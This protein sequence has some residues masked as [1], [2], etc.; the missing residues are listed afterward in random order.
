MPDIPF[1]D[2]TMSGAI[3]GAAAFLFKNVL[4]SLGLELKSSEKTLFV[5]I[6]G[7]IM[8]F[9][10]GYYEIAGHTDIVHCVITGLVTGIITSGTRDGFKNVMQDRKIIVDTI[11]T[12]PADYRGDIDLSG[13]GLEH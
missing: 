5:I 9:L 7:A 2:I 6:L 3:F 4:P 12:E 1:Y 13:N 8:G 11:I 10:Y